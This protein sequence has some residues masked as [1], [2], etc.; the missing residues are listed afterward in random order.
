MD[1]ETAASNTYRVRL[2]VFEGPIDLLLYLVRRHEVDIFDVA[3]C[4]VVAG[5]ERAV[6]AELTGDHASLDEAAEFMA[7]AANLIYWKSR[8]LLPVEQQREEELPTEELDPQWELIRQLIEYKKFK[9]AAE[10]LRDRQIEEAG[11]FRRAVNVKEMEEFQV[12]ED[13][14]YLGEVGMLDLLEALNRV[15]ARMEKRLATRDIHQDSFT[16]ADKI[17]YLLDA[18]EPGQVVTFSELF[19]RAR[20]ITE[21]VVTFLAMLELIR[22]RHLEI[23]QEKVLGEIMVERLDATAGF[24]MSPDNDEELAAP[25]THQPEQITNAS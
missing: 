3:L 1:T 14:L 10:L 25:A 7:F 13:P 22:L 9:E 2:E 12:Q 8:S 20:S 18:L 11:G 15:L 4:R 6:E 17:R 19:E 24:S 23:K 5:F 21:V 16:V